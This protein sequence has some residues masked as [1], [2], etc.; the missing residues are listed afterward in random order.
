[1]SWEMAGVGWGVSPFPVRQDHFRT[2]YLGPH[3][4]CVRLGGFLFLGAWAC[5]GRVAMYLPQSMKVR[6]IAYNPD[7]RH[8]IYV[9]A[10]ASNSCACFL[11][12]HL[13][14]SFMCPLLCLAAPP[15]H[16]HRPLIHLRTYSHDITLQ[17]RHRHELKS[18]TCYPNMAKY[19]WG[20]REGTRSGWQPATT[21]R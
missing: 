16:T 1:V 4:A 12:Y 10:H 2:P 18:S 6:V 13:Y 15:P 19:A 14:M 8:V 3:L 9:D 17:S 21:T 5:P 7:G 20:G 11:L